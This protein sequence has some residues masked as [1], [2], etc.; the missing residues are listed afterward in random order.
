M[1]VISFEEVS[2]QDLQGQMQAF[3]NRLGASNYRII[4]I[5]YQAFETN[6]YAD[7]MYS[8]LIVYE[9]L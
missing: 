7:H 8:V 6:N 4:S 3:F 2:L 1:E 5:N 9:L